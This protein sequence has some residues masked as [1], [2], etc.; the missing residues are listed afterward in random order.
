M[1]LVIWLD[2]L[3]ATDATMAVLDLLPSL[4]SRAEV[5]VLGRPGSL[6]AL[7]DDLHVRVVAAGC[8]SPA[9]RLAALQRLRS[10][11]PDVVWSNGGRVLAGACEVMAGVDALFWHHVQ[12]ADSAE[13]RCPRRRPDRATAWWAFAAQGLR[14]HGVRAE[15]LRLP[16][17]TRRGDP[18]P[19]VV[20]VLVYSLDPANFLHLV[21]VASGAAERLAGTTAQHTELVC[22]RPWTGYGEQ[23]PA[24]G[25]VGPEAGGVS[26]RSLPL[27]QALRDL[28]GMHAA[29]AW[30]FPAAQCYTAG[31]PVYASHP[32]FNGAGP[33]TRHALSMHLSLLPEYGQP[34]PRAK[35]EEWLAEAVQRTEAQREAQRMEGEQFFLPE[36][37]AEQLLLPAR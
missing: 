27:G 37:C 14:D 12:L 8:A 9:E 31:V 1:R 2:R 30:G 21:R 11:K 33:L 26:V 32:A 23:W 36:L 29:F 25:D 24:P 35:E 20:R 6:C 7:L 17:R 18:E 4:K 13:L 28:P 34:E 15:Q 3:V 22:V 19:G 5:V 10:L 16:A